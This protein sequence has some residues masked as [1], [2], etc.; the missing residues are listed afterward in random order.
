[1]E[2]GGLRGL[3]HRVVSADTY[4]RRALQEE[5]PSETLWAWWSSAALAS[6]SPKRD[7]HRHGNLDLMIGP[8]EEWEE[9]EFS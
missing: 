6:C 1:M 7:Y 5:A 2:G 9:Q 3:V 8:Q 4:H